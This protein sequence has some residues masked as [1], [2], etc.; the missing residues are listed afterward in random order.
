MTMSQPCSHLQPQH[1]TTLLH[2]T[3]YWQGSTH[4]RVISLWSPLQ[5][6][7]SKLGDKQEPK[8]QGPDILVFWGLSINRPL[9]EKGEHEMQGE[10]RLLEQQVLEY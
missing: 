1:S 4:L 7:G 2:P 3:Q 9:W 5:H 10:M 6:A 8:R